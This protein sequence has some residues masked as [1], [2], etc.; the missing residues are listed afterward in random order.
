[1]TQLCASLME[2]V[3]SVITPESQDFDQHI[4]Q[5]QS[6]IRFTS[7]K[8]W[9]CKFLGMTSRFRA[10]ECRWSSRKV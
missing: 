9:F 4:A 5:G 2:S 7:S 10:D 3:N 8:E 1:M 6:C